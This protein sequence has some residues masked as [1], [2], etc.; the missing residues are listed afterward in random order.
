MVSKLIEF[1]R[2]KRPARTSAT[3]LHAA[4]LDAPRRHTLA[5]L[6][7]LIAVLSIILDS[8]LSRLRLTFKSLALAATVTAAFPLLATDRQ[9][10]IAA[11]LPLK[12]SND[13][14]AP[15]VARTV[16]AIAEYSR[17]PADKRDLTL[18]I[19][20]PTSHSE[21]ILASE[22]SRGR[23]LSPVAVVAR[24]IGLQACD[25]LYIGQLPA[26]QQRQLTDAVRGRSVLTIAEADPGCRSQAMVCLVYEPDGL[27]FQLNI[28]AISRSN[29]AIDPRV[30][31]MASRPEARP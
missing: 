4:D 2:E 19:V 15:A 10:A 24:P 1:S 20:H 14:Y 11:N 25:A 5:N 31:R 18:C 9:G 26:A 16:R 7:S 3:G 29:I 22:L 30:L 6:Q 27:T 12:S 28:D 21:A 17:W 8:R 23:N 13:P